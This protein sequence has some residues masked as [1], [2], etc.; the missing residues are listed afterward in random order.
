MKVSYNPSN[1]AATRL[2]LGAGFRPCP[3]PASCGVHLAPEAP[4][5][6]EL[7]SG[8]SKASPDVLQGA[9]GL[10]SSHR[11]HEVPAEEMTTM[12]NP[13][14]DDLMF[15]DMHDRADAMRAARAGSSDREAPPLVAPVRA[16]H[17]R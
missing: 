2:Y 17:A 10:E 5:C 15:Q 7:T 8:T 6:R 9:L 4:G 1:T 16:R 12:Y 14:N 3:R 13:M 11:V